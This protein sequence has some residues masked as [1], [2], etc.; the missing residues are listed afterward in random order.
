MFLKHKT[1][2]D[3]KYELLEP[4]GEGGM[5]VLYKARHIAFDRIVALKFISR[6]S[7]NEP[8]ACQRF[9][10]EAL[11]LDCLQHRN[12]VSF[13]GYGS[14][15]NGYYIAL[16]YVDGI[17]L[18][19]RLEQGELSVDEVFDIA[20]QV[21]DGLAHAHRHGIIHRDLKPAN[22]MLLQLDDRL[23]VKLVDFG[24]AHL[25]PEFSTDL[26][27]LTQSGITVGSVQYMSP[28]QCYGLAVDERTDI[29]GLGCVLYH[30]FTGCAPFQH[31]DNPV[32]VMYAH[33]NEEL[34]T[35]AAARPDMSWPR[36][37]Q[38]ALARAIHKQ[39]S[40]R[41]E[42][43][44]QFQD[45]LSLIAEGRGREEGL[46]G[47]GVAGA[48]ANQRERLTRAGIIAVLALLVLSVSVVFSS[49]H[50]K[51]KTITTAVRASGIRP[52]NNQMENLIIG[53]NLR[54]KEKFA[55]SIPFL[56]RGLS[57]DPRY[58]WRTHV[59][60]AGSY[61][62]TQQ[63]DKTMAVLLPLLRDANLRPN[64]LKESEAGELLHYGWAMSLVGD[65]YAS[66]Q[67]HA[68]AC[69]WYQKAVVLSE[70]AG[71][72]R[73][74]RS[75]ALSQLAKCYRR[76][77]QTERS[78]ETFQR[79][80]VATSKT[81]NNQSIIFQI[82]N[83]GLEEF[84]EMSLEEHL[85]GKADEAKSIPAL[86]RFFEEIVANTPECITSKAGLTDEQRRDWRRTYA[87]C[88]Y[89]LAVLHCK[90]N[91]PEKRSE[92]FS[93]AYKLRDHL[94]PSGP[95][96]TAACLEHLRQPNFKQSI[97]ACQKCSLLF[98]VSDLNP[99]LQGIARSRL[100]KLANVRILEP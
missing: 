97:H 52:G 33:L 39:L 76:L 67:N 57:S 32:S 21:C 77:G 94:T 75:H 50:Q 53:E 26:A 17:T 85:N 64:T 4:L 19:Q 82:V 68:E 54:E 20:I 43:I 34:P 8:S 100:Q 2:I 72:N 71:L 13:L 66:K 15:Q 49:L 45:E 62:S 46:A 98:L 29:Y 16:E 11:V 65:S 58:R 1:L 78:A 37:L 31:R 25:M 27:K 61:F 48:D 44:A 87:G 91:E 63:A 47:V 18:K 80:L 40:Q 28:E 35:L 30:C 42:T 5:G 96:K 10:R 12:I 60:L 36:G 93:H 95:R 14:W 7:L 22:I 41:Y 73:T 88:V 90:A 99:R 9:E 83:A 84:L 89:A 81:E 92:L 69:K 79:A 55:E 74:I 6:T 23:V 51:S 3:G 70:K 86:K 24:L 59:D 38:S 56:E